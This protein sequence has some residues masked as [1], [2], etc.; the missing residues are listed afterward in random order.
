MRIGQ[1]S[2]IGFGSQIISTAV[3]FLAT[4]AIVRVLGDDVF[5]TYTVVIS[6]VVWFQIVGD[7]GV[8][9]AVN[10]RL[11][12][13][14]DDDA[15]LLAGATL[16]L[17]VFVVMAVLLVVAWRFVGV[18]PERPITDAIE[19]YTPFI[20]LLLLVSIGYSFLRAVLNG[21]HLVHVA[22]VLGST[23]RSLRSVLHLG[24]VFVGLGITGLFWGYAVSGLVAT[25]AGIA[26]LGRQRPLGITLPTRQHFSRLV[27]YARYSWLGGIETQAFKSMDTIVLGAFLAANQTD[28]I[29]VYEVGWNIASLFAV[30]STAISNALFPEVSQIASTDGPGRVSGLVEDALAYAGLFVIPG[31]VGAA[32]LGDAILSI[33]NPAFARGHWVLVVLVI[34]RLV[35]GYSNQFTNALNAIDRP[36]AAFRVNGVFIGANLVLNVVFVWRYGWGGAAVATA[37]SAV[38]SLLVGYRALTAVIDVPVPVREL[39]KQWLSA[40]VMGIVVLGGRMAFGASIPVALALAGVGAVTYFTALSV[41]SERFRTTVRDNLPDQLVNVIR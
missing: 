14:G 23:E 27:S 40:A 32:L 26:L 28:L 41:V 10:K 30:F 12:E 16:Q 15:Y 2:I 7:L 29:A 35:Y 20:V 36:D 22:A 19:N 24:V 38:V 3:G 13:A 9:K 17:A 8:R 39:L 11:S 33:Y 1:T 34:A 5:G 37:I 31:L 6:V 21:R 4:L 18:L 25:L